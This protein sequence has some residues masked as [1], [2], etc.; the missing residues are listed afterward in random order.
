MRN[1]YALF[2]LS[3]REIL[4]ASCHDEACHTQPFACTALAMM[5][6]TG[7][8]AFGIMQYFSAGAAGLRHLSEAFRRQ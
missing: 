2:R 1:D 4:G 3:I 8:R 7:E 5:P 6:M